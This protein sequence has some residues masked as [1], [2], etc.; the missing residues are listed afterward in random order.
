[1]TN[2]LLPVLILALIIL[3]F[4]GVFIQMVSPLILI[5]NCILALIT[6][7]GAWHAWAESQ[8]MAWVVSYSVVFAIN[9]ISLTKQ[10]VFIYK[11]KS[12]VLSE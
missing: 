8:Q 5:S 1:M 4:R 2:L 6:S 3:S 11:R 10:S 7:I 9:L 12:Q